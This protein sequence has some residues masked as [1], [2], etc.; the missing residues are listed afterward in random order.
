MVLKDIEEPVFDQQ[1]PSTLEN[2]LSA[3]ERGS[4]YG[5]NLLFH[6]LTVLFAILNQKTCA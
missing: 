6:M 5:G 1:L 3:L 4:V 2:V